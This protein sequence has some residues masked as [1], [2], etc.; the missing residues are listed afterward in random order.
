MILKNI[1]LK[2]VELIKISNNKPLLNYRIH[3]YIQR[4]VSLGRAEKYFF[5]SRKYYQNHNINAIWLDTYDGSHQLCHPDMVIWKEKYWLIGTPYPYGLEEYENPSLY[6]GEKVED[7][8]PKF[9]KPIAVP[10]K[11]GYGCHLSD[12]C[13]FVLDDKLFCFYRETVNRGKEIENAIRYRVYDNSEKLS[14][15]YTVCS[16]TEDGLLSPA[17]VEIDSICYMYYVSYK[18][19]KLQLKRGVLN[20]DF[21]MEQSVSC[22]CNNTSEGWNLWH[23]GMRRNKQEYQGLFLFREENGTKFKLQY[24]VLDAKSLEWNI[25]CDIKIPQEIDEIVKIPYKSCF[26]PGEDKKILLSFRDINAVYGLCIIE[27]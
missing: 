9:N 15:V 21:M 22:K 27:F 2:I 7:M 12:P 1:V 5:D 16:S 25:I 17:I 13:L 18:N 11:K 20:S 10:A 23:I 6:C 14:K 26:V 19:K 24:A 3:H 8:F 4:N